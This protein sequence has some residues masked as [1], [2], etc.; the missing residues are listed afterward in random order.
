MKNIPLLFRFI[1]KLDINIATLDNEYHLLNS[2]TLNKYFHI[3][4]INLCDL[5]LNL[6]YRDSIVMRISTF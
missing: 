3:L 6:V 5:I 4:D 2:K 1:D